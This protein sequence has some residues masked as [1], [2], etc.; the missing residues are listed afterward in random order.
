MPPSSVFKK[1]LLFEGCAN[2]VGG[3][4]MILAPTTFL[5]FLLPTTVL[6]TPL[7]VQLTQWLGG[8]V[9]AL[10]TPLLLAYPD[11]KEGIASRPTAYWTLAAGEV[12]LLGVMGL[13]M[14]KPSAVGAQNVLT[15][16]A[17]GATWL[18]LGS[19]LAWRLYVL[20]VKPEM[21]GSAAGLK[22]KKAL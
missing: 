16:R 20:L 9:L 14:L 10:N 13:Q 17:M 19:T 1:A 6:V 8:I 15:E 21:M 12:A 5:R 11:T 7:A 22:D 18:V 3:S 4:G 2:L